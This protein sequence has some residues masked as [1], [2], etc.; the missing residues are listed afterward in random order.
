MPGKRRVKWS[1]WIGEMKK[2][3]TQSAP[4][5]NNYHA[6]HRNGSESGRA[7]G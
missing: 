7:R 2:N 1:Q 3:S 5:R 4:N 6:T